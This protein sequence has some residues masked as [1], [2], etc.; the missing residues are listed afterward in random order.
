MLRVPDILVWIRILLFSAVIFK[1]T[2][3]KNWRGLFLFEGFEGFTSFSK[4]KSHK[5]VKKKEGIKVFLT[6]FA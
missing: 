5:E 6:I 4:I 1:T 2:I 3:K